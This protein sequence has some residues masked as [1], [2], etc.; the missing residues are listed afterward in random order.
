MPTIYNLT[1]ERFE[2]L[3]ALDVVHENNRRKWLCLCDC[4]NYTNVETAKLKNGETKSC[5]CLRAETTKR[6]KSKHNM[7]NT[8]IYRTW[9]NMKT[10]CFNPN[11]EFFEDY[12]GRG[13]TVCDE[14]SD[15]FRTFAK[16]AFDNGYDESLTIERIDNNGDYEP[17]NCKW[18]T[19]LEQGR[20]KRNNNWLSIDGKEKTLSEWARESNI[21]LSTLANR[22]YRGE[23][24]KKL[25]RSSET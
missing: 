4:G 14:W 6:L 25:L 5:G 19:L 23:E 17:S 10:R 16:W 2:R 21:P 11:D 3:T 1:G 8:K 13:I 24:G 18:A 22:V 15:D 7:K 20:N 12:G 9:R